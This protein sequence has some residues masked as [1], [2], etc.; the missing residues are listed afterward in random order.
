MA[1]LAVRCRAVGGCRH[2][3]F[4][5][6][7]GGTHGRL[8]F[9][10]AIAVLYLTGEANSGS[11]LPAVPWSQWNTERRIATDEPRECAT[12]WRVGGCRRSNKTRGKLARSGH[13][14]SVL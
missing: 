6:E 7:G 10:G 13:Q 8:V 1:D 11:P 12:W 4:T 14:L 2:R 5:T 9:G 3:G